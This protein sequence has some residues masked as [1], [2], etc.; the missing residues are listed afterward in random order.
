MLC[1]QLLEEEA[2]QFQYMLKLATLMKKSDATLADRETLKADAVSES[3]E[4]TNYMSIPNSNDVSD[5]T[6]NRS[7]S[8]SASKPVDAS[9]NSSIEQMMMSKKSKRSRQSHTS[10]NTNTSNSSWLSRSMY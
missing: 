6:S 8:T 10:T 9:A 5:M 7:N 3:D 4:L 2:V 1:I